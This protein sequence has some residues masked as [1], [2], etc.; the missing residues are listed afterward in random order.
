MKKF[1]DSHVF[2][3][4][5]FPNTVG[6]DE[7]S[8]GAKDG[9]EY[10]KEGYGEWWG[11]FQAVLDDDG[12]S[13]PSG[14]TELAGASDILDSL[15]SLLRFNNLITGLVVSNNVTD[16]DHDIDISVGQALDSTNAFFLKFDTGLIK[17]IDASW[18]VGTN[19]GGLF[20]GTVANSTWYAV[21]AIRADADGS[22]DVGFD[23]SDTA[24]NIPGGYTAFRRIGWVLTDGSA[25]IIAFSSAERTG[26]SVNYEWETMISDL[27]VTSAI[28][29]RTLVTVS[30]PINSIADIIFGYTSNI[31]DFAY[32][33]STN[34]AD[35]LPSLTNFT[36]ETDGNGA[37]SSVEMK[38]QIDS[39]HQIAIRSAT[40][41]PGFTKNVNALGF[42]DLR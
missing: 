9:S 27:S 7:T 36:N 28:T 19:A 38:L 41:S 8:P 34:S 42:T 4:G 35:S 16:S 5:T 18:A 12:I 23:T 22:I 13:A 15:K 33:R 37:L 30:A 20:T 10:V 1:E 21:F 17:Q 32:A 14:A 24:A 11:F 29:T 31:V 3:S 40:N 26:G 6:V 25:N 39:S 2:S